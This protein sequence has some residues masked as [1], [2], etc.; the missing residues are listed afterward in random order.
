MASKKNWKIVFVLVALVQLSVPAYMIFN[1]METIEMGKEFKFRTAPIDPVDPFRGKYI[2]LNYKDNTILSTDTSLRNLNEIYVVVEED[3][4][5]MAVIKS[6][7]KDEPVEEMYYFKAE[8]RFASRQFISRKFRNTSNTIINQD[9]IEYR[10]NFPFERYYMEESKS[11]VAED[12][13]RNNSGNSIANV[14]AKVSVYKGN[15]VLQDVMIHD[16]PITEYVIKHLAGEIEGQDTLKVET[17]V[18]A[19]ESVESAPPAPVMEVPEDSL[20]SN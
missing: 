16:M 2:T 8:L 12:V 4:A 14:Y 9:T 6:I 19:M 11:Q 1:S 13:A 20:Q 17:T 5:G 10:V 15:A 3:S 18:S 7:H